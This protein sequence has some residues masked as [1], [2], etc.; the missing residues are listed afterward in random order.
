M[1]LLMAH[2][3]EFCYIGRSRSAGSENL[4][5]HSK[6]WSGLCWMSTHCDKFCKKWEGA[7]HGVCH[8]DIPGMACFCYMSC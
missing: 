5:K 1:I 3:C 6:M 7:I 8:F 2:L 4:S